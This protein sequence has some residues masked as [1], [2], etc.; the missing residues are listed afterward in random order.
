M[1]RNQLLLGLSAM[2]LLTLCGCSGGSDR[3]GPTG[4]NLRSYFPEYQVGN[5]WRWQVKVP[6]AAPTVQLQ[7]VTATE[8]IGGLTGYR[9][10]RS[11]DG[12]K[13]T[14]ADILGLTSN[15]LLQFG[16][17]S[18]DTAGDPEESVRYPVAWGVEIGIEPGKTST[19]TFM[20]TD[21]LEGTP[22]VSTFKID[23]NHAGTESVTVPAGTFQAARMEI[24]TTTTVRIGMETQPAEISRH[25]EWRA[26]GVGPVKTQSDDG[27]VEELVRAQINGVRF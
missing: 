17:D 6:G 11:P 25:T 12:G 21:D 10:E 9:V 14:E 16:F 1:K 23:V 4:K 20:L 22:V 5:Q 18:Y 7:T 8:T 27:T 26:E 19:Q 15:R 2:T 3:P 24:T 13:R